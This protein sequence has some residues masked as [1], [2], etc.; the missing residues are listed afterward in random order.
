MDAKL[1]CLYD[2]AFY[3]LIDEVVARIKETIK[4]EKLNDKYNKNN[5]GLITWF[6]VTLP[7]LNPF[8]ACKYKIQ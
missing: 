8:N 5:L 4:E 2:D 3:A 6:V 7:S 1:N